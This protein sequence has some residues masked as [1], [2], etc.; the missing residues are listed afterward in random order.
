MSNKVRRE[1]W[2]KRISFKKNNV[3]V[4]PLMELKKVNNKSSLPPLEVY[5][6]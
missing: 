4:V 1:V 2:G 5:R 3:E 6:G